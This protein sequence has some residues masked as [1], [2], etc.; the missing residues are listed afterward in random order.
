MKNL[1][2]LLNPI[3]IAMLSLLI[4]SCFLRYQLY[5]SA[6][7]SIFE[8]KNQN[9]KEIYSSDTLKISSRL[10]SLSSAINWVCIN[11]S[12]NGKA[13]YKSERDTCSTGV[14]QQKT[15]F[16]LPEANNIAI[17]FTLRLPKPIEHLFALFIIM[18]TILIAALIVSTR[19]TE[20]EKRKYEIS[21]S[22]I[23]RQMS[24]DIRSPLATLN[25]LIDD[26]KDIPNANFLLI[27]KSIERINEVAN[28]LLEDM[29][30]ANVP[31]L[32]TTNVNHLIRGSIHEK[33]LEYRGDRR[34]KF[35]HSIPIEELNTFL[36]PIEFKR[37]ISNL[38]NNS[39]EAMKNDS[40]EIHIKVTQVEDRLI[41]NIIDNGSG[42]PEN[43]LHK[44]G[45][46]EVTTKANGNGLGL[47]H[48]MESIKSWR[49]DFQIESSTQTGT[50]VTITFVASFG[51]IQ[52]TILVDDDELVR[53]TWISVAKKKSI[54]FLALK[55]PHQLTEL[56][57]TLTK[58]TIFYIDS[59]LRNGIKGEDVAQTLHAQGFTEIYM[60]SGH[61]K[62]HF[63]H[64]TFL[65]GVHGKA[66]PWS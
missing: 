14:F 19:K 31:K 22:K 39:I 38:I 45:K 59:E 61:P 63:S 2:R 6:Q 12:V 47:F 66:P 5:M 24:H 57:K 8:F 7:Q 42:I 18:Q 13:F 43:V 23:A 56:L 9:F 51:P 28:S 26:I 10:N 4:V 64:L 46:N 37:I 65:K 36:D 53:I 40:I 44:I 1:L 58:D 60:A 30:T 27:E 52:K 34:I 15:E 33:M 32:I 16:S 50:K 55:E 41:I 35:T 54:N 48:A 20:E 3:S 62:E 29:R 11:A 25:T 17:T 49:G 21:L